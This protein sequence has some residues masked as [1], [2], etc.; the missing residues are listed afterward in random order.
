[1]R[2]YINV[3]A[4]FPK[5]S[6][7]YQRF[8]LSFTVA[9][10]LI[11]CFNWVTQSYG[12]SLV[13]MNAVSILLYIVGIIFGITL[14][15]VPN[16][17][18]LS[19]GIAILYS[20]VIG[21]FPIAFLFLGQRSMSFLFTEIH[22]FGFNAIIVAGLVIVGIKDHLDTKLSMKEMKDLMR[23]GS[24]TPP[25]AS[26]TPDKTLTAFNKI[27]E[28]ILGNLNNPQFSID[29]LA[30]ELNISSKTIGRYIKKVTNMTTI[31]WIVNQRL[32]KA[33][34]LLEHNMLDNPKDVAKHVG[35]SNYSYFSKVYTEKFGKSPE[36]YFA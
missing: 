3:K 20:G 22:I 35:Y 6:V 33:K 24:E 5:W 8:F 30:D 7:F 16:Y 2:D 17:K 19:Y 10:I 14:I 27:N 11:M 15:R 28:V 4:N 13:V 23:V 36:S 21:L 29:Y 12:Y 1:M 18:N 32:K 25:G 9:F 26:A 31:E 34:A